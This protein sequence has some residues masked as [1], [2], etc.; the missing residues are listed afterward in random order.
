MGLVYY[1]PKPNKPRYITRR[2]FRLHHPVKDVPVDVSLNL[3][4][5]A[6]IFL[7]GFGCDC[8]ARPEFLLFRSPGARCGKI[9]TVLP[10]KISFESRHRCHPWERLSLDTLK[11]CRIFECRNPYRVLILL[12]LLRLVGSRRFRTERVRFKIGKS[13]SKNVIWIGNSH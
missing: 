9:Q 10:G 12:R 7:F 13:S 1:K 2:Q 4:G 11:H 5:K 8:E 3:C 6:L